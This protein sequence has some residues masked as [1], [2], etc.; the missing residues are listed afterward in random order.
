MGVSLNL[1]F[2]SRLVGSKKITPE[3][4][5]GWGVKKVTKTYKYTELALLTPSWVYPS[6]EAF[7]KNEAPSDEWVGMEPFA[8]RV[9]NVERKSRAPGRGVCEAK[10]VGSQLLICQCRGG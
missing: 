8:S 5:R 7:R 6:G 1:C 2:S 10:S 3:N 9:A 4:S